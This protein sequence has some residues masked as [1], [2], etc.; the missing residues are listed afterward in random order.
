MKNLHRGTPAFGFLLGILFVLTGVLMMTVGFW[1]TVVI[2]ALFAAGFFIGAVG[3]KKQ[4]VK[5][6]VNRVIPEKKDESIDF[7]EELAREQESRYPE[8]K[9]ASEKETKKA[10]D[11]E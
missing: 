8:G 9:K 4:F 5:N 2:V 3:D 6:T 7:R 10:E 11:G 1:K